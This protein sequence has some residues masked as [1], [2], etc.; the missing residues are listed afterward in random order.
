MDV[1][2]RKMEEAAMLAYA[3]DISQNAD[4]TSQ[5]I[6]QSLD[7]PIAETDSDVPKQR[8]FPGTSSQPIGPKK[9]VDPLLPPIDIEELIQIQARKQQAASKGA[10]GTDPSMWCEAVT[11]EGHTYYWNVK[12]NGR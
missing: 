3:K 4:I 6:N 10:E 5:R 2:F 9:P 1:D 7:I 12:T 8:T 11:E